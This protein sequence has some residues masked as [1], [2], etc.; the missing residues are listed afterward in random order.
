MSGKPA[1]DRYYWFHGQVK[2]GKPF[3]FGVYIPPG[4]VR[5]KMPFLVD[6]GVEVKDTVFYL[7][8][9]SSLSLFLSSPDYQFMIHLYN[10]LLGM[11]TFGFGNGIPLRLDRV[12]M[13]TEKKITEDEV[14]F[15]T[16]S[17]VL[18]QGDTGCPSPDRT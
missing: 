7:P 1:H 2:A 15:K 10:G 4:H 9:V 6:N 5:K 13:L 14:L 17:L 11:K 18:T 8:E 16:L 3:Y 12:F